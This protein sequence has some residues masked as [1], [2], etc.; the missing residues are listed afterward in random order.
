MTT[1]EMIDDPPDGAAHPGSDGSVPAAPRTPNRIDRRTLVG[2]VVGGAIAAGGVVVGRRFEDRQPSPV[3]PVAVQTI[4]S[5]LAFARNDAMLDGTRGYDDSDA[6]ARLEDL[7]VGYELLDDFPWGASGD[8]VGSLGWVLASS[9][10]GAGLQAAASG[11]GGVIALTPGTAPTGRAAI[12]L[13]VGQLGGVPLFTMEFRLRLT[14]PKAGGQQVLVGAADGLDGVS[15]FLP[16]VGFFFRTDVGNQVWTCGVSSIK[17]SKS[18]VTKVPLDDT[19]HRMAVTSDGA[20]LVRFYVDDQKV[21]AF[22]QVELDAAERYGHVASITSA[23]N[24]HP[25]AVEIDW[26]FVRRELAR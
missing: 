2:G 8:R 25:K 26:F 16:K 3:G 17:G 7:Q 5:P 9:G 6:L 14:H 19:F 18:A 13:D 20:G 4:D 12:G 22:G 11:E 21:A 24:A 23:A 1:D 10:R 15:A